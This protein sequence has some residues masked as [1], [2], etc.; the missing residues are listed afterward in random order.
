LKSVKDFILE[1]W[2]K[3]KNEEKKDFLTGRNTQE[4]P[5]AQSNTTKSWEIS[6][7]H[8]HDLLACVCAVLFALV[9][10]V[11]PS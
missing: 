10:F 9:L 7:Q 6:Q 8:P 4:Q 11:S 1:S 2:E 5:V 3:K